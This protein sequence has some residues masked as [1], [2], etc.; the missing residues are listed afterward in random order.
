MPFLRCDSCSLSA[1]SVRQGQEQWRWKKA[2]CGNI[3]IGGSARTNLLGGQRSGEAALE[4]ALLDRVAQL[5]PN[6]TCAVAHSYFQ[7][8]IMQNR[9]HIDRIAIAVTP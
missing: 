9:E 3:R 2:G 5:P 7:T 4:D 6:A 1:S 8:R